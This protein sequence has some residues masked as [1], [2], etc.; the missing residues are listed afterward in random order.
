[1]DYLLIRQKVTDYT[2][3]RAFYD[4]E[5]EA[6]TQ[7]GI[8]EKGLYRGSDDPNDVVIFFNITD[9]MQASEYLYSPEFVA[10]RRE[11]LAEE[12]EA[13]FLL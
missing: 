6:R 7:A 8:T 10:R 9:K 4:A 2:R 1:M 11:F 5:L 3:W 13:I 12:P